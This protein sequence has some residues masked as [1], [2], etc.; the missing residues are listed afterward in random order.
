M[1]EWKDCL[2]ECYETLFSGPGRV[3]GHRTS[4]QLLLPVQDHH[5]NI[6][7][8]EGH[9]GFH[10]PPCPTLICGAIDIIGYLGVE[11]R[12][13]CGGAIGCQCPNGWRHISVRQQ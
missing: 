10:V 3:F 8:F 2:E 7:Q 13:P 11:N 9:K 5:S 1:R 6:L 4:P 12:F